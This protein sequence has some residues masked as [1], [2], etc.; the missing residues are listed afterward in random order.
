MTGETPVPSERTSVLRTIG[1]FL[2]LL[3]IAAAIALPIRYFIAQPFIVRG[4]SMEPNFHNG[5]YLVVDELSYFFR[6]PARGEVVVFHYPL[7]PSEYFIKRIIGL[8]DEAVEIKNGEVFIYNAE[9]PNGSKLS[10]PYLPK[11]LATQGSVRFVLAPD[12]F[13]VL[14]DNRPYSSD[15]RMW[16]IL[17]REFITGR[18][19][20]R[21]WPPQ[22]IGLLPQP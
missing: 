4:A 7:N 22:R 6:S 16:G 18:S 10:E 3:V 15:S 19:F 12:E 14:G 13:V 1:E 5:E 21:A 20:F 11:D 8:P 2:R 9:H 17:K